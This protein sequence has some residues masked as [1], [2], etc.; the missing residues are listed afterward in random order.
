MK[1]SL[2]VLMTLILVIPCVSL[3]NSCGN[4]NTYL[5]ATIGSHEHMTVTAPGEVTDGTITFIKGNNLTFYITV[6]FGYD[7][8]TVEVKINDNLL[9]PFEIAG[10]TI[11]Y[12]T[13]AYSSDV[14]LQITNP[15]IRFAGVYDFL[16]IRKTSDDSVFEGDYDDMVDIGWNYG[17]AVRLTLDVDGTLKYTA[18]SPDPISIGDYSVD[19]NMFSFTPIGQPDGSTVKEETPVCPGYI[20]HTFASDEYYVVFE[21]NYIYN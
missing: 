1:K 2:L 8:K 10:R 5:K 6:D 7:A 15:Q 11:T 17:P 13:N 3:L 21:L 20:K 19:N 12:S 16:E 14:T 9:T 4:P 18:G